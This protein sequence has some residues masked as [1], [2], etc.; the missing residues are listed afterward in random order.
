PPGGAVDVEAGARLEQDVVR[1]ALL[2]AQEGP[3]PVQVGLQRVAVQDV[4]DVEVVEER[5]RGVQVDVCLDDVSRRRLQPAR[6]QES[7]RGSTSSAAWQAS[8]TRA[9]PV[10]PSPRTTQVQPKP[11]A[12]ERP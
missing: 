10:T 7:T 11:T 3:V 6:Q 9:A 8:R 4:Q 1:A 5:G 12:S 2:D